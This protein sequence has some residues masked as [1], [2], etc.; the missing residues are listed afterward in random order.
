[1]PLTVNGKWFIIKT[2]SDTPKPIG[3]GCFASSI[4]LTRREATDLIEALVNAAAAAEAAGDVTL[5][6]ALTEQEAVITDKL[7]E[8]L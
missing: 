7:L 6:S 5:W 1:L 8:G 4:W 3:P 2:M